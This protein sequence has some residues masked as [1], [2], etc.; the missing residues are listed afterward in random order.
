MSEKSFG[1][2]GGHNSNDERQ[3]RAPR[4]PAGLAARPESTWT[5]LQANEQDCS[6]QRDGAEFASMGR[7]GESKNE[8]RADIGRCGCK[9]S[10]RSEPA[11]AQSPRFQ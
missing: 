9:S 6:L 11:R 4:P 5:A 3:R 2:I 1:L 10:L 7:S 8:S